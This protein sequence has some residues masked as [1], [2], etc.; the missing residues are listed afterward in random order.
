MTIQTQGCNIIIEKIKK[1][2][3][4]QLDGEDLPIS[5]FGKKITKD[6]CIGDI[7]CISDDVESQDDTESELGIPL[8]ANFEDTH[9]TNICGVVVGGSKSQDKVYVCITKFF[10]LNETKEIKESIGK[11]FSINVYLDK[12]RGI[13]FLTVLHD[14]NQI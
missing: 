1:G 14:E 3:I 5:K 6:F 8:E 12:R 2:E 10:G 9:D 11:V 4:F 7:V 13:R